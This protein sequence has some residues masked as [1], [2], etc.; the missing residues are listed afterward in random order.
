MSAPLFSNPME[1]TVLR[2]D[3]S[4]GCLT[5]KVQSAPDCEGRRSAATARH[6]GYVCRSATEIVC[7]L[8]QILKISAR[9]VSVDT[10]STTAFQCAN[11]LTCAGQQIYAPRIWAAEPYQL[12]RGSSRAI[13]T[14]LP[15]IGIGF[16]GGSHRDRRHRTPG[17]GRLQLRRRGHRM[18]AGRGPRCGRG[19]KGRDSGRPLPVR[20]RLVLRHRLGSRRRL[21][22]GPSRRR[23][24]PGVPVGIGPRR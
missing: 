10:R 13:Q 8:F 7:P 6:T 11:T 23:S 5:S 9:I 21:G 3:R 18:C 17:G 14:A 19:A 15:D 24:V 2:C 12:Q 16:D 22:S 4:H 1:R 20:V